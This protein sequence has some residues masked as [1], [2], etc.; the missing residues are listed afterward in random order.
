VTSLLE[1]I[2]KVLTFVLFLLTFYDFGWKGFAIILDIC[3]SDTNVKDEIHSSSPESPYQEIP[4]S[5]LGHFLYGGVLL[6]GSLGGQHF[7]ILSNATGAN[8]GFIKYC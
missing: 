4:L 1:T 2:L 8:E 6:V 7:L 5:S 3:V